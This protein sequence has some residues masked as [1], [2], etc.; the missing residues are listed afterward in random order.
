MEKFSTETETIRNNLPSNQSKKIPQIRNDVLP[1]DQEISTLLVLSMISICAA[2]G[3]SFIANFK[4]FKDQQRQRNFRFSPKALHA[5]LPKATQRHP[6][7]AQSVGQQ[8]SG[9]ASDLVDKE[10]SGSA[11]TASRRASARV[12]GAVVG[13][14]GTAG[15]EEELAV[16]CG[17]R[18][19]ATF[20]RF[21]FTAFCRSR[22]KCHG[23]IGAVDVKKVTDLL[24]TKFVAEVAKRG[25]I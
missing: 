7:Q 22:V 8:S 14:A 20:W 2:I 4:K 23:V 21:D 19:T 1:E 6:R 3:I 17:K 11:A 25:G 10:I 16:G 9:T 13:G 5:K 24:E 15:V 12:V 18:A